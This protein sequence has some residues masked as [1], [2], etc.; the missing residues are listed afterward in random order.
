MS[1]IHVGV[2]IIRGGELGYK[3]LLG[4][5]KN[6]WFYFVLFLPLSCFS[7]ET[8]DDSPKFPWGWVFGDAQMKLSLFKTRNFDRQLGTWLPL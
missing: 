5:L 4:D 1:K 7:F 2:N 3:F 6:D 8:G